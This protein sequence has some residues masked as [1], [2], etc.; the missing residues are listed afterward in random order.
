[1]KYE[2][3]GAPAEEVLAA[4]ESYLHYLHGVNPLGVAYLTNMGA[5]GAERSVSQIYHSWFANGSAAWDSAGESTYGPAPGFLAGGPNPSYGW[6][7]CCPD[8][9]GAGNSC[10]S[11]PPSPPTGQPDQKSY[12][13]FND[14]WP[15]NSWSVTENSNGYQTA[16]I[17]LLSQ[18]VD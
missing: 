10:G 14:N 18:F 4:A 1:V 7:G 3:S 8:G 9:C 5:H 15:L 16:Y 12:F 6:D 11:A 13:D 17:R 2:L